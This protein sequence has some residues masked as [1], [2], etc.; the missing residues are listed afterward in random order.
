VRII[1]DKK[2]EIYC[3][4]AHEDDEYLQM[5]KAHLNPFLRKGSI[6]FWDDTNISPG[7][8][9]QDE[10][11]NHLETASM[12]LLLVSADFMNSDYCYSKEMTRVMQQHEEGT[13]RVIPIIVRPV[14]WQ[15]APFGKLQV[16]PTGAKAVS[17]WGN[18]D[19]GF[20]D[21]VQG[22]AKVANE[23]L[24]RLY[25]T[26][27]ES[28]TE[29]FLKYGALE[30][31]EQII[32]SFKLLRSQIA[33]YV[34]L[35]GSKEFTLE[36]CENQY[37][38]LYGNTMVFLAIY[39]PGCISDDSEGFVEIVYRKRLSSCVEEVVFMFLLLD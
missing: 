4:Y 32:Q 19:Q 23:C 8:V 21:I 20:L 37:N 24:E 33:S 36:R 27:A 10:V 31:L 22:I 13:I 11:D 26:K 6:L 29:S 15:E 38:K 35:N 3:C 5:L 12:V 25:P 39:L 16:L 14:A 7:A 18:R 2:V 1:T 28:E 30:Q 17:L 34:H 9:W